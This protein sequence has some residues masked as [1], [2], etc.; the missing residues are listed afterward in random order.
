MIR[1]DRKDI[2][3]LAG[4]VILANTPYSLYHALVKTSAVQRMKRE[5]EPI[6]LEQYYDHVTV[7]ARRT[8]IELGIAYGI[9]VAL[10]TSEKI[11]NPVDVSRL[12]WGEA[13]NELVQK[14]G[15]TT[16]S[17]IIPVPGGQAKI[18]HSES[19]G[20]GGLIIPSSH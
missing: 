4:A 7:R 12:Q 6:E 13:I 16:Q 19:P 17:L 20:S 9:L 15:R 11:C 5:C 18:Q 1:L 10:L 2:I 3:E 14:S 8:E